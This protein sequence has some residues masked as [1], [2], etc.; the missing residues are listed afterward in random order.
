MTRRQIESTKNPHIKY[1]VKLKERRHR[2]AEGRFLIEGSKELSRAL[3]AGIRLEQIL[4]CPKFLRAEGD[5]LL[6]E[7][8]A[9]ECLEVSS[10]AFEKLSFRQNPD[11]LIALASIQEKTLDDIS[12][13]PNALLLVI[14]GLEKP[15]NVGALL[16]TADAANVDAVFLTGKGTDIYNPNVIRSSVGSVF[17][18][19]I[20][21]LDS[22]ELISYLKAQQVKL[23][24]TSPSATRSYWDE[25]YLAA[26]AII[27]GTEHDGLAHDWFN[28]AESK[29]IIPMSGMTDSL[30]VATSGALLLYEV[31]RQRNKIA[32]S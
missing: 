24:A 5:M 14:D 30:N 26:T 8:Q 17:S 16:R 21:A 23:V 9:L 11:G 29:V 19:P 10:E 3:D 15:G 2:D 6:A 28:A 1:L 4:Y 18:R 7:C 27:L 22:G 31:M 20:L 25:D 12:L 32:P 13:P